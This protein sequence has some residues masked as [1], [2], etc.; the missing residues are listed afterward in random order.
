MRAHQGLKDQREG[1]S[2]FS[3]RTPVK[4]LHL[5]PSSSRERVGPKFGSVFL[6]VLS[7]LAMDAKDSSINGDSNPGR[8]SRADKPLILNYW[9][10]FFNPLFC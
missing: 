7:S 2:A 3:V 6:S 4:A 1:N 5:S 10:K 8:L 9:Q